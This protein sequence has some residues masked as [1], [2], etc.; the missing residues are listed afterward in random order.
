MKNQ[1]TNNKKS[2]VDDLIDLMRHLRSEKGCPWDK[3]QTHASLKQYLIEESAEFLDAVDDKDNDG[4][5]EELGDILLHIV[6][7]SQMASERG[8]F[9]FSDVAD[10]VVQKMRRR[11]PHVFGNS[12]AKDS[13][14]VLEMWEKIKKGE[15]KKTSAVSG[16]RNLPAL[17]RAH[18][19]QKKA[20]K[21]GFDWRSEDEIISKIEEE[22]TELK[23]AMRKGAV[24]EIEDEIGDMLFSLVNLARFLKHKNAE[25]ILAVTTT[26]F[27]KR[28]HHIEQELKN[29]NK[30]FSDS[31]I[32]EMESLWQEAKK[33][34]T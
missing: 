9:D 3:E 14:E 31:N 12:R 21:C 5:K 6:F 11:H 20:A 8:A 17:F 29:R 23:A 34:K 1:K 25:E 4:M 13:A 30:T 22:L 7:H 26:K 16:L 19:V 18:E 2:P 33:L 10:G 32:Q 24:D 28:F 15:K 27:Q